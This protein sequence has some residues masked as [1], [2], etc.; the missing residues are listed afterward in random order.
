MED[1]NVNDPNFEK[2]DRTKVPDVILVKKHYGD[3][4]AR[5]RQR[6]WKLKH[7]AEEDTA[8]NVDA[9]EYNE[10]LEDLEEDPAMRQHVNIFKDS[11]KQIPVDSNDVDSALPVITLEEMLDDLVIDDVEMAE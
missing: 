4:S 3:K 11:S 6:I 1:S 9:N 10:F 2:L 5:K 7:L 8:L